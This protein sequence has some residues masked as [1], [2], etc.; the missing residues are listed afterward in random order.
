MKHYSFT[1]LS[2]FMTMLYCTVAA[3]SRP[4]TLYVNANYTGS[5]EDGSSTYPYK[6]IRKALD[7]R[8]TLGLAG[9]TTDEEIVVK[10]GEYYPNGS[11]MLII[12]RY[13]GGTNG[14]W[15][16][17][18]SETPFAATIHGDSLYRTMFAAMISITDSA[19]YV[20][21]KNFT[22]EH[23]RC[24]PDSTKWMATNGT[25]TATVP[26]VMATYN[27][28]PVSDRFAGSGLRRNKKVAIDSLV[29]K[30]GDLNGGRL[31]VAAAWPVRIEE[32]WWGS[33]GLAGARAGVG[34][35]I[36]RRPSSGRRGSS[37]VVVIGRRARAAILRDEVDGRSRRYRRLGRRLR[38]RRRRLEVGF[39]GTRPTEFPPQCVVAVGHC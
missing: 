21:I 30:H 27:G 14:K 35:R 20:K 5:T 24:N 31:T 19:Q 18:K 3:Q 33:V 6:T 7:R 13:N 12:N 34:G 11:D 32:W 15:L 36:G 10:P 9:M 22:L 23:L 17:I 29:C 1:L 37:L 25:Y 26:T 28:Q 4:T 16:T 8:V 2:F 38:L 39:L